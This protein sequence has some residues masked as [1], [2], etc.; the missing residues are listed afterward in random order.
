MEKL[1]DSIGSIIYTIFATCTAMIGYSIYNDLFFA[2]IDFFFAPIAWIYWLVT[3][4]VNMT[5]IKQT[6]EFFLK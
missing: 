1:F 5:I 6:F 3:H 2:I 4:Q